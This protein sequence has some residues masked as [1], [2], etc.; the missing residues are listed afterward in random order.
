[1]TGFLKR[2]F[3]LIQG[4]LYFY[5]I[6]VALF[7]GVGI[8]TDTKTS[9]FAVY[10]IIFAM[11]SVMGLFNYDD[12]NRW[13]SYGAA[14]PEGRVR[15]VNARYFLTLLLSLGV[16]AI[17]AA[18]LWLDGGA[19]IL[20]LVAVY[21]GV[22]FLYAAVCLPVFY[23]FG[24]TKARVVMIMV[25]AMIAALAGMGVTTLTLS[26]GVGAV[27]LPPIFLALPLAGLAALA[28]SWRISLGIMERKEL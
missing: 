21:V 15:M 28:L 9:F 17:Q 6:F 16:A 25:V 1:M 19:G 18:L 4:N 2:D 24:G 3:Y 12:M 13:Q 23:R 22:F 7:M 27:S 10:F 20:D 8:F 11:S 14:A 5:L 26:S